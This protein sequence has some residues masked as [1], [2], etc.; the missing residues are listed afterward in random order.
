[1]IVTTRRTIEQAG[2]AA[3][4][5]EQDIVYREPAPMPAAPVRTIPTAGLRPFAVDEALLM[6]FSALT[7]NAHRIHYDVDYCRDVEG[8][9]GLV[10]HGPLQALL[11][12]EH[13]R[14][15]GRRMPRQFDYRLL[16]PL[17]LGEGLLV[18][19]GP[20]GAHVVTDESGRLTASGKSPS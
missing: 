16:A 20:D 12:A 14:I 7:Y 18:G 10:V 15:A 11:M 5:D 19:T 6:R 13:T 4:V 8:Y 3:V 17:C 2:T 9:P 1:M